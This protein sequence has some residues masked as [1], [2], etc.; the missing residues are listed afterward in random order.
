MQQQEEI[1]RLEREVASAE[2]RRAELSNRNSPSSLRSDQSRRR[3]HTEHG[4]ADLSPSVVDQLKTLVGSE[5]ERS[6]APLGPVLATCSS[7]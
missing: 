3:R 6:L 5:V 1:V 2:R 7:A 4:T